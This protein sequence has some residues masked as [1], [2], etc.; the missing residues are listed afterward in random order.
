M[1]NHNVK[2]SILRS[3]IGT[4]VISQ[5]LDEPLR[6]APMTGCHIERFYPK[7]ASVGEKKLWRIDHDPGQSQVKG[8][9]ILE[10]MATQMHL[11]HLKAGIRLGDI[12]E[13]QALLYLVYG[14]EE[15]TNLGRLISQFSEQ[16]RR[17]LP[18][19]I[20][21]AYSNVENPM[22]RGDIVAM[23]SS[24]LRELIAHD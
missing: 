22:I 12:G 7:T 14:A 1:A 2:F 9:K 4:R 20:K 18:F 21:P 17:N 11:T 15:V 13:G 24:T 3:D 5:L 23:N 19:S 16:V 10:D 6:S 8:Q